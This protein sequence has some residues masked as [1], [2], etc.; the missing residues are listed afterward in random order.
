MGISRC[1]G[2]GGTA[3]IVLVS[4]GGWAL[5]AAKLD[6]AKIA[7]P[8]ESKAVP[9]FGT[10]SEAFQTGAK[11]Y[12]AGDKLA[13]FEA[14]AAAAEEGHPLAQWKLGRMYAEGDGVPA[15][16]LKA[17]GY[18]SRI[19]DRQAEENPQS[20]HAPFV[21]NAFVALGAY[22]RDGIPGT[23]VTP[24]VNRAV[25]LFTYAAS[26]FGDPDGQYELARLYLEGEGVARDT[27]RAARWLTLAARK[28]HKGAQATLG[29][30]LFRGDG[31]P[32]HKTRGLMWL[33]LARQAA[34]GAGDDWILHLHEH[35]FAEALPTERDRARDLADDLAKRF[36][37]QS[38]SAEVTTQQ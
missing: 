15:D 35:A 16:P 29:E 30:L 38:A 11:A 1:L 19:A 31:V 3:V 13:A 6:P 4:A 23:D 17:F 7:G 25:G 36:A 28:N 26:Y 24:D 2:L 18:F 10:P 22:H 5:D 37:R 34:D 21:A 33:E 9:S 20:P 32:Q 12:Y 27:T 14:L 8:K